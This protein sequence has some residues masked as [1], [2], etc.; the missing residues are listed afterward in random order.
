MAEYLERLWRWGPLFLRTTMGYVTAS[1]VAYVV[2]S[3][4]VVWYG[5]HHS[6]AA[7]T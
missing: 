7:R 2:G 6:S 5:A 3:R 1:L 4:V